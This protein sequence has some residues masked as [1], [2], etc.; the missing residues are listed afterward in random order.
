MKWTHTDN[1]WTAQTPSYTA[2]ITGGPGRYSWHVHV[3]NGVGVGYT[4]TLRDAKRAAA[5]AVRVME[6]R[7]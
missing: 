4:S 6:G 3:V 7:E 2:T 5:R 1:A